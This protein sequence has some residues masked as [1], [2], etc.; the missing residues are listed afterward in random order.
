M[1]RRTVVTIHFELNNDWKIEWMLRVPPS[2]ILCDVMDARACCNCL[3]TSSVCCM[4][5][6]PCTAHTR[7]H[8]LCL[9]HVCI[10]IEGEKRVAC[11][12]DNVT[13][14]GLT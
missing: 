6:F 10:I 5:L 13:L 12:R 3:L 2:A 8:T 11:S 7:T 9:C 14:G 1:N 4:D